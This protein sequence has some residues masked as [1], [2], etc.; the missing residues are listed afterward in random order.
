MIARLICDEMRK[1]WSLSKQSSVWR[2]VHFHEKEGVDKRR[3][4]DET[5][6]YQISE[7]TR[8]MVMKP[9]RMERRE[10]KDISQDDINVTKQ[11]KRKKEEKEKRKES[12]LKRPH[13][14]MAAEDGENKVHPPHPTRPLQS[15]RLEPFFVSQR[16]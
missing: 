4:D 10:N 1:F 14:S 16:N 2:R 5:P 13:P 7:K 15:S 11:E 12:P 8:T 6:E 3:V 9:K